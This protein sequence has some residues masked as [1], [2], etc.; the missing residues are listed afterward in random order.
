MRNYAKPFKE[1]DPKDFGDEMVVW[2]FKARKPLQ[3]GHAGAA[4]LEVRRSLKQGADYGF[5]NCAH[6]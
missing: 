1:M 2:D 3:V 6:A 5:T 4:P